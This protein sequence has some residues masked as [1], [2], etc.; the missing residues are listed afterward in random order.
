MKMLSHKEA[1]LESK[2]VQ[3][4]WVLTSGILLWVGRHGNRVYQVRNNVR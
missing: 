4:V 1:D 3:G 2:G